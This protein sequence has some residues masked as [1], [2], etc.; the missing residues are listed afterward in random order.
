MS[1]RTKKKIHVLGSDYE[2]T[3]KTDVGAGVLELLQAMHEGPSET[4]RSRRSSVASPAGPL[5][6]RAARAS[7]RA[8]ERVGERASE[9]TV[10]SGAPGV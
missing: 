5:T 3:L 10:T 8:G 6:T 1:E 4:E 2:H 9:L 7:E